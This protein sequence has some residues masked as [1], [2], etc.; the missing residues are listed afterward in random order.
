MILRAYQDA[1]INSVYAHLRA[2]E[3]NPCIVIPTGGGKTPVIATLCRDAVTKWGG[4]VLVLA[5]VKELL[6]Q[7]ADALAAICPEI[8]PGVYSAGLRARDTDNPVIVAGIQSV[9]RR[10]CDL[11]RFDLVLIDEAH[12]IPPD[13]EGMYRTFLVDAK[14]VNPNVRLI[15]LTATPFRMKSGTIADPENLL[16]AVCYEVG[17]KE[18]IRDGYLSPLI[19]KAGHEPVN[20]ADLHIRAGEFVASETQALMDTDALVQAA[21]N[22]ILSYTYNR[23]SCLIFAA[24]VTHADHIARTLR[25]FTPSVA[26]VCGDTMATVRAEILDDFK[27]GKLRYL[28]N[29]NVLTTGF[30]AP[31]IDCIAILRPTNSPGLYYQ[32]VGRGF[33]LCDGKA[34]CLILDY[35]GNILRH[36]PVD[37]IRARDLRKGNGNGGSAPA[38]TC[39]KCNSVIATGYS[40][41]PDC[42]YEFPAPETKHDPL[43]STAGVLSDGKTTV[44]DED[45]MDVFYSIHTKKGADTTDPKTLRVEYQIALNYFVSEWVCP[46]HTG[47]ARAKFDRWW[48]ER[49]AIPA[50]DNAAECFN[51]AESGALAKPSKIRVRTKAGSKFPDVTGY[52]LP[53]IPRLPGMDE[54]EPEP[55]PVAVAADGIFIDDDIP[56]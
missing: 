11:G 26:T 29:V 33:R 23:T 4:R 18:L 45:V 53:E 30:D 42:G 31:N 22:E 37:A 48:R 13:G 12:L 17:V 9:Y 39:P 25:K 28:V 38:K 10:A 5:H 24:G 56:F 21:C 32:M 15:G 49:C 40:I 36:G 2:R 35:G 47:F 6:Q 7:A 52:E 8:R 1:A 20:T 27:R 44:D 3:D 43:A 54:I 14:R 50:P 46:E 16:N 51:L 34:D 55:E 19:S 41:C